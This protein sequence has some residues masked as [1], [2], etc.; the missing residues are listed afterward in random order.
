MFEERSPTA[1]ANFDDAAKAHAWI[2]SNPLWRPQ[3]HTQ[4]TLD[5][6]ARADLRL[7]APP[8]TKDVSLQQRSSG[9]TYVRTASKCKDT[10]FLSDLPLY[11]PA[12]V[13]PQQPQT[14]YYEL[15]VL[16]MGNIDRRTGE[17]DA[18][19]AIGF[20]APPYPAWRLPG[21]HRGSLGVHGDDGRRYVDNSYGGQDFTTA[22][23]KGDVV[24]IGMTIFPPPPASVRGAVRN[25]EVFFTRNGKKDGGWNL[26]EER[27]QEEDAGDVMGLEGWHDL[28]AAVGC[29]GGVEFEVIMVRSDWKFKP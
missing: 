29:F 5:R 21:W 26:H 18:G 17:S 28:L 27:D 3:R 15:K 8:G 7:T 4:Q 10:I 1:N 12:A 24:G 14:I 6:I 20:V 16:S 22:F 19:I 2:R 25:V 11:V 13:S 23:K 9:R